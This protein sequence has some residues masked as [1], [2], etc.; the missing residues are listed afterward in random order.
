MI[1]KITAGILISAVTLFALPNNELELVLI[2]K[3][4]QKKAIVISNMN[5]KDDVKEKF[6][7][8]YDEYQIK[9]MEHRMDTIAL[10]A[11]YAKSYNN[12]TNENADKLITEWLSVGDAQMVL[13]KEY[14]AKFKKI[15]PSVDVIRYFQ[16]EN[17]MQL[18]R[19]A[20][21]AS[22]IP[23]AMPSSMQEDMK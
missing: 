20:Q 21:T 8:L 4:A 15:I 14:M 22:K 1:K 23:L 3:A 10:I 9:L 7:K 2:S 19:E 16:I 18:L 11:N 12:L 13:K 5:L 6:G 17:R